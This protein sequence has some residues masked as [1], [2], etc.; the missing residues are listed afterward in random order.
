MITRRCLVFNSLS[1]LLRFCSPTESVRLLDRLFEIVT[2][3]LVYNIEEEEAQGGVVEGLDDHGD[4]RESE[5]E[6]P[7]P[8]TNTSVKITTVKYLVVML[9]S[10]PSGLSI[11]AVCSR[12]TALFEAT[13]HPSVQSTLL[14]T[15]IDLLI[16]GGPTIAAPDVG[17]IFGQLERIALR[18]CGLDG[19]TFLAEEDWTQEVLPVIDPDNTAAS[20]VLRLSK[21]Q[22][23][24]SFVER[25]INIVERMYALQT[26][27]SKRW[28]VEYMRRNAASKEEL[29]T[30]EDC[31]FGPLLNLRNH[32][33]YF[34]RTWRREIPQDSTL[35]RLTYDLPTTFLRG[36]SL[37][38]FLE[39]L[40]SK[41][42]QFAD[43][44]LAQD[45][46]RLVGIWDKHDGHFS[47][48]VH[49][50]SHFG[51]QADLDAIKD[52]CATL[53]LSANKSVM[54]GGLS[55]PGLTTPNDLLLAF[56]DHLK[57]HKIK[58][59]IEREAW[60]KHV[61]P[62]AAWLREKVKGDQSTGIPGTRFNIGAANTRVL[63]KLEVCKISQSNW[64]RLD[65]IQVLLLP[66]PILGLSPSD[67]Y[68]AFAESLAQIG[69]NA[70]HQ[71]LSFL[72]LPPLLENINQAPG[73]RI[74][75][76][77]S[78]LSYFDDADAEPLLQAL[79]TVFSKTK[80]NEDR[81]LIALLIKTVAGRWRSKETIWEKLCRIAGPLA[82]DDDEAVRVLT[83]PMTPK[84]LAVL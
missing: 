13:S 2:K 75:T 50:L 35:I 53:L 43:E 45:F 18:V 80:C 32:L 3:G 7:R 84:A 21:T 29:K 54:P 81:V 26:K 6:K 71:P 63:V 4:L 83:I 38:P 46:K 17:V 34:V 68:M 37:R 64:K 44:R 36:N 67:P 51:N 22:V 78:M 65:C 16:Q 72:N 40:P 70:I 24:T 79:I 20:G 52:V 8:N 39:R 58:S 82:M 10:L 5:V 23:P 49:C 1:A 76:Q 41:S 14:Q 31:P 12:L 11:A 15:F 9:A 47:V 74:H 19:K 57:P 56:I 27:I 59:P 42:M 55:N 30:M 73:A 69:L 33:G 62:L 61:R 60:L 28:M 77:E 25:Y 48:I 66:Y